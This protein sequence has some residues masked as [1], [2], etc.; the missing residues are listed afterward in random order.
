MLVSAPRCTPP[1]PPVAKTSIPARFAA[2]MV[3]AT[4]VAP[5]PPP[6]MQTARSARDSLATPV[7]CASESS[8][9]APSPTCSVP[10]MTAMVAGTAPAARTS[11]STCRAV[12]RFWG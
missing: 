2:I 5:V 7:A 11:S 4:V 6:A 1:M 10:S 9:P 8:C 3:A 12:S